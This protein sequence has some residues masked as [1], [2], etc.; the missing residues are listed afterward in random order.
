MLLPI[1][2]EGCDD[3]MTEYFDSVGGKPTPRSAGNKRKS[4][5]NG[6]S[7]TP[8]QTSARGR[9]RPKTDDDDESA[10]TPVASGSKRGRASAGTSGGVK[11]QVKDSNGNVVKWN[12]PKGSWEKEVIAVD[13]LE[14][15]EDGKLKGFIVWAGGHKS[16]HPTNVLNEKCPQKMLQFYEA[17]L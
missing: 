13:T 1:H 7:G 5:Q 10:G 6:N 8:N 16:Q 9:K 14:M 17:H 12:A 15:G 11:N 4:L 3:K 2:S